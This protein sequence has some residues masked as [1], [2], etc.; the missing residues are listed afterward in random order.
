[1]EFSWA[2]QG[3]VIAPF[4]AVEKEDINPFC[5]APTVD[6]TFYALIV[7]GASSG[8]RIRVYSWNGR[9]GDI[10]EILPSEETDDDFETEPEVLVVMH[11]REWCWSWGI[12][13]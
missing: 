10:S 7:D 9:D 1:M 8:S 13:I 5:T 2:A 11:R 6:D 12:F 4:L 3:L